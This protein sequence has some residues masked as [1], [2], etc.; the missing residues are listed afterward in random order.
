MCHALR[1]HMSAAPPRVGLTQALG[2]MRYLLAIFLTFIATPALAEDVCNSQIPGTLKAAIAVEFPLFRIPL[3]TDNLEED[4]AWGKEENGNS[5]LGVAKADFDGNSTTDW[6]IGLT[7]KNGTGALVVAALS[8]GKQWHFHRLDSW[9][10]GR[11]RLYVTIDR[12]GTYE[13][14]IGGKPAK[15]GEVKR[16][17]CR[18]AVAV[19]G[20]TES[21]GVAYCYSRGSWKHTW[22]SD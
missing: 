8:Q 13:S 6:L 7:Q 4:V 14:I 11:S 2:S 10:E 16:L 12:P 19:F 3:V 20:A 22:I 17:V 5:C 18:H 21:S 1:L 9:P 15:K